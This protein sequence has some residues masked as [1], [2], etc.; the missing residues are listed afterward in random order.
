MYDLTTRAIALHMIRKELRSRNIPITDENET[1][2]IKEQLIELVDLGVATRKGD[3]VF[4]ID[5][6]RFQEYVNQ[7]DN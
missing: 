7:K 5:F 6:E 3:E 2:L 4:N 1:A